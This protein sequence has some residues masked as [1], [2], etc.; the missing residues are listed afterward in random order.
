MT[1]SI[2]AA[3]TEDV[4]RLNAIYS[5]Y[6]VDSHVSFDTVPWT[7]EAR[8][9]WFEERTTAG[10]P[11]LV[12]VD[13]GTVVGASW[14]GP[15]RDKVAYAASV[16]TT[17]VLDPASIGRGVGSMLYRALLSELSERGIHRAYAIIALPNDASVAL[18]RAVGYEEIGV[19]DEAG[20]KNG[21]YISTLLMEKKIGLEP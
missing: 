11:V 6:I 21:R 17:I 20:F 15:W 13:D 18:H 3:T 12:A 16:E 19:L 9:A 10:Y 1:T 8:V 5:Q 2:R 4:A 14:A 7:D